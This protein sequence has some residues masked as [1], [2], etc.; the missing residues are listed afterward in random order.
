MITPTQYATYMDSRL[1][2]LFGP[3]GDE[4]VAVPYKVIV[5]VM[6]LLEYLRDDLPDGLPAELHPSAVEINNR[7]GAL[8]G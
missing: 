4:P 7:L 8:T 3:R 6:S 2:D 5:A 1:A